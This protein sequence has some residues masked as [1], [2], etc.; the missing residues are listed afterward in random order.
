MSLKPADLWRTNSSRLLL[1]FGALFALWCAAL[2][3]VIQWNTTRYLSNIVD[4]KLDNLQRYFTTLDRERLR[5]AIKATEAFDLRDVLSHGVFD[6]NGKLLMGNL[7]SIPPELPLDGA[8]HLLTDGVQRTSGYHAQRA[9]GIAVYLTSGELLVLVR[10]T[11]VIDAVGAIIWRA[12]LFGL[13]LIVVPGLIGA[14]LLSRGPRRRVQAIEAAV[15]PIMRGDLRR[16]LPVS[17]HG[18]ELDLLAGIVNTMLV[19]IERLMGEVKGVCDNIA[20]DLRTPLTRLRAQL[21]RLQLETPADDTR[22][23]LIERTIGDADALLDRFRALLRI[24]ELEDMHRRAG[25]AEV[26][27]VATLKHVREIYAPLAEDKQIEF[28]LETPT[29][30]PAVRGDPHLVFEALSNLVDNAIKFTPP[31]GTVRVHTTLDANG[32]R[33]DVIDNGPGIRAC[34]R[35]AV[36]QR[37]YR[38]GTQP[39]EHGQGL[40]L[41]IV[42]A[43]VK[44]HSFG[45]EIGEGDGA[46]A[47][48]S[49]MCWPPVDKAA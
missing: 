3:G 43:I 38:G 25:F 26:D 11:S 9:R 33:I 7:A 20:H 17:G 27:L 24:S 48:V 46:G 13:P 30:V 45:L 44:L 4:L 36:V 49:L 22:A 35:G 6:R 8:V 41:A 10:D 29:K 42:A 14:L 39:A 16:R 31:Q 28:A 34:D 19:E 23:A 32:P 2:I 37:F 21:H 18:D 47:K 15:Q 5:E 12:M 40:G 1:I